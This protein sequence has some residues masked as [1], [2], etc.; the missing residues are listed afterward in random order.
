MTVDRAR[1]LL[2]SARG[3]LFDLD[4]VLVDSESVALDILARLLSDVGLPTQPADLR[5][6][7]GRSKDDLRRHVTAHYALPDPEASALLRRFDVLLDSEITR[8]RPPLFPGAIALATD[9]HAMG[10]R[11]AVGSASLRER[12]SAELRDTGLGPLLGA[13]VTGSDVAQGKPAPDIFLLCAERLAVPPV[14]CVVLEDAPAGIEAAG[15][16]GMRS[17]GIAH[18]FELEALR[19]ADAAV[20]DLATLARAMRSQ[21]EPAPGPSPER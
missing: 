10:R 17:I 1:R 7:C 9:L 11:L 4:G 13:V 21:G 5:P 2:G 3:V 20:P 15:R 14:E 12:V 6:V 18:T 8:R 16:A 19:S